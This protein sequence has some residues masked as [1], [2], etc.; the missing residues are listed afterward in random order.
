MESL[1]S[2]PDLRSDSDPLGGSEHTA[3]SLRAGHQRAAAK[4]LDLYLSHARHLLNYAVEAGI[5]VDTDIAQKIIAASHTADKDSVW[6]AQDAG[7]LI[8]AITKLATK[9]Y[10]VTAETLRACRE[11]AGKAIGKYRRLAVSLAFLIV[12]LSMIS[13]VYTG[14]SNEISTN[15]KVANELAVALHTQLDTSPQGA[16]PPGAL[17]EL[18]QFAAAMRTIN[19]R[20]RQLATV[21][22]SNLLEVPPKDLDLEINVSSLNLAMGLR[23][24]TNRLTGEYQKV[25]AY[26][27]SAQD[28]TSVIWGAVGSCVLPV[29]YALLGACAFVLRTFTQQVKTRTFEPSVATG[30]R[31]I[32]A[33]I[34]GCVLGLFSVFTTGEGTTLSPLGLAFIIGYAADI[35]FSFL[36]GLAETFGR[37]KA[38][39]PHSTTVG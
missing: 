37:G 14:L 9:L 6:T 33:A 13:F 20:T 18:Q 34:G 38:A 36:E 16:S 28:A 30:A 39:P 32:I 26:A 11:D 29:L 31:L 21:V 3:I 2:G 4:E 10:P 27:K 25:R 15:V 19:S 17:T 5:E 24:E 12:P 7:A 23:N 8:S 22:S 1:H 35:F